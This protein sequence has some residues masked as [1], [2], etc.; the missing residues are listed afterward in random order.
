MDVH[1]R[2]TLA[3]AIH[4]AGNA[5]AGR[6]L[7]R[8]PQTRQQQTRK[9]QTLREKVEEARR[10]D[11]SAYVLKAVEGMAA[12][13]RWSFAEQAAEITW[14]MIWMFLPD[15]INTTLVR[16]DSNSRGV[17]L[18]PS[19]PR[20]FAEVVV[21]PNFIKGITKKNLADRVAILRLVFLG[22]D[23][24]VEKLKADFGFEAVVDG[25]STWTGGELAVTHVA[26]SKMLKADRAALSGVTLRR[27]RSLMHDGQPKDGL[28]EW[29][30][31][32]VAAGS[33]T[34]PTL[35]QVLSLADSAFADLD[36]ASEIV[37]HEAGHGVETDKRRRAQLAAG[38]A[39]AAENRT[40]DSLNDAARAATGAL[41]SALNRANSYLAA[42]RTA[43]NA[44]IQAV[45][46]THTALNA[47]AFSSTTA[48]AAARETAANT[49]VATRNTRRSALPANN[50][51]DGD[52]A[53]A[54]DRQDDWLAAAAAFVTARTAKEQAQRDVTAASGVGNR[55]ISRRL[56][57]FTELVRRHNIA[58]ITPYARQN[59]PGHPEEFFAEAYTMWRHDPDRLESLARPLKEFFDTGQHLQ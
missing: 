25:S 15:R 40:I 57:R 45:R 14:R 43:A 17:E 52:F 24:I 2:A 18:D 53:A 58:P 19:P 11:P 41:N 3:R 28:F 34:A 37:V 59:W 47:F 35:T 22:K 36:Q 54:C 12:E 8:Q 30:V 49:A 51:A 4:Q 23:A 39:V 6:Y 9:P 50:P 44:F 21:G 46:A 42:D 48:N 16:A 26:L 13:G 38:I 31:S 32:G 55:G 7:A 56:E 10:T 27:A 5:A 29:D 33:S 20:G 1:N